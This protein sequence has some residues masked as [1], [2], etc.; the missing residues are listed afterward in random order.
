MFDRT[1]SGI[2]VPFG[3]SKD[4]PFG[5]GLAAGLAII[6]AAGKLSK[7]FV[8]DRMKESLER[9]IESVRERLDAQDRKQEQMIITRNAQDRSCL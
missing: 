1:V 7:F 8:A 9:L 4:L 3:P 5:I 2:F 6:Q